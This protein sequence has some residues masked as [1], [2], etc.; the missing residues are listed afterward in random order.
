MK[1]LT[2]ATT[3]LLRIIALIGAMLPTMAHAA[4]TPADYQACLRHLPGMERL[5]QIPTNL[6]TAISTM[7][8]GRYN[9]TLKTAVP[10]PWTI[11]VRGQGYYF[12]SKEEAISAVQRFMAQGI[13]SIDVG[14]MQI[15]LFYHRDAFNNLDQAFDPGTNV[16][17]GAKFL[18]TNYEGSKS[19]MKATADYHS[20]TPGVGAEYY[21]SVYNRW[22]DLMAKFN[23]SS[24][25]T[26]QG[27]MQLASL[28][29][30][31]AASP[32]A[33]PFRGTS[34][35]KVLRMNSITV[36]G[37]SGSVRNNSTREN[38][39][40]VF[41]PQHDEAQ[42]STKPEVKLAS[43]SDEESPRRGQFKPSGYGESS[44]VIS[45]NSGGAKVIFY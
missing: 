15:N 30:P 9:N 32:S 43:A 27:Q 41:R 21:R 12:D 36:N 38:G 39:V 37:K 26:A 16:A 4:I 35:Y 11:N 2:I 44:G 31:P 28:T 20:Q 5:Q 7:E 23:G 24:F 8:S 13:Q 18:R 14:C 34:G 3:R 25:A 45:N 33:Q 17:Y 10:W 40:L 19:W 42:L 29:A 22:R 1:G 6:L